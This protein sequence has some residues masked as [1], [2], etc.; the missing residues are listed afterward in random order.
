MRPCTALTYLVPKTSAMYAGI[1]EKPPPYIEMMMQNA[2]TNR[3]A[4]PIV[5]VS[6]TSE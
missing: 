6:G 1:V 5:P 4:L 2:A 3:A